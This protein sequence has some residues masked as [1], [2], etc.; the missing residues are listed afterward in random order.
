MCAEKRKPRLSCYSIENAAVSKGE[1]MLVDRLIR[2]RLKAS[3]T[4]ILSRHSNKKFLP[5]GGVI[6]E[7]GKMSFP[8]PSKLSGIL[9][10][11]RTTNHHQCQGCRKSRSRKLVE[12]SSR[13]RA[14]A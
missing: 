8:D 10:F 5:T 13:Q 2:G 3:G 1:A 12:Y 14:F 9:G 6:F 7:R 11:E 4:V